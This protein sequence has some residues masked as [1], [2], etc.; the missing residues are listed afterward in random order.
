MSL[1][2]LDKA[3]SVLGSKAELARRAGVT[4]QAVSQWFEEVRPVPA[5]RCLPIEQATNGAVTRYD[6]RPD[7]FGEPERKPNRAGK[8]KGAM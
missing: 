8:Q 1:K 2:A 5:A 4:P 3:L 7:I 6:L